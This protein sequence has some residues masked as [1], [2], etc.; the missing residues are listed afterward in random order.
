METNTL[1]SAK[2]CAYCGRSLNDPAVAPERFGE[3]FCSGDHAEQFTADVRAA[4]IQL[5]ASRMPPMQP[6]SAASDCPLPRRWTGSAKRVA[7]WGGP[8]LAVVAIALVWGGG[9]AATGG[10]LLSVA[11]ALACPTAM[12]F[13]M[14]GMSNMPHSPAPREKRAETDPPRA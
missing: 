13:M 1:T 7:C 2:H 5:A 11:A 10:S 8:L 6:P 3:R 9:W 14:R 12:Y 4:R